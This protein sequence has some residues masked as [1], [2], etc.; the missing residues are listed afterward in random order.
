[1]ARK[2]AVDGLRELAGIAQACGMDIELEPIRNPEGNSLVSSLRDTAELVA[3]VDSNNVGIA[4]DVWHHWDSATAIE[5][6]ANFAELIRSVHIAD[7]RIPPRGKMDR[8]LPGEGVIDL[9]RML[10]AL[11]EGGFKGWYELE[12]FSDATYDDSILRIDQKEMLS[13]AWSGFLAAWSNAGLT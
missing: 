11:E 1:M 9:A 2:M 13:R 4:Y 5:D 3:D 8:V 12:V 7:W 10:A 6:I